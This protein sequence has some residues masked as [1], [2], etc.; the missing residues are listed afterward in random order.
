[1]AK[2]TDNERWQLD[3]MWHDEGEEVSDI[4]P[5]DEADMLTT[6]AWH[7]GYVTGSSG[8]PATAPKKSGGVQLERIAKKLGVLKQYREEYRAGYNMAKGNR[9]P[10]LIWGGEDGDEIDEDPWEFASEQGVNVLSHLDFYGGYVNDDGELIGVL[11][12]GIS[13]DDY[14][15]DL[16]IR[17][18]YRRQGLASELMDIAISD[19]EEHLEW[20][21]DLVFSLD[22]ISPISRKMLEKRGFR[23]VGGTPDRPMMTRNPPGM[24][25]DI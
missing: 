4:V 5:K 2:L 15:F 9:N 12:T 7:W 16:A 25:K 8:G 3:L 11:F 21:P 13:G 1:M 17:P 20:N 14:E 6:L 18:D 10:E 23:V 19:Y 22:V 24:N